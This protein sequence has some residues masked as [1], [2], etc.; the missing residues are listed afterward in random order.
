MIIDII[1]HKIN[2]ISVDYYTTAS[3]NVKGKIWAPKGNN[4]L[5][6]NIDVERPQVSITCSFPEPFKL[7]NVVFDA[8]HV[9]NDETYYVYEYSY[10]G[11]I[12]T[13]LPY[14][15]VGS[16]YYRFLT[17][18]NL[19]A[20]G[21]PAGPVYRK[22]AYSDSFTNLKDMTKCHIVNEH[23]DPYLVAE[24]VTKGSYVFKD[25]SENYIY[26]ISPKILKITVKNLAM[27]PVTADPLPFSLNSL[28]IYSEETIDDIKEPLLNLTGDKLFQ[29]IYFEDYPFMPDQIKTW[30]TMLEF[31]EQHDSE[32][33]TSIS[34]TSKFDIGLTTTSDNNDIL[35][36]GQPL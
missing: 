22:Y 23:Q 3:D 30:L 5:T 6:W 26:N 36:D 13:E 34:P 31:N 29:P 11:T 10:E 35:I 8:T 32:R 7:R 19:D 21:A 12:W 33:Y 15:K 14:K 20:S 25:K 27:P 18:Y 24:I 4:T 1:K 28:A 17:F 2:N 16:N 9:K